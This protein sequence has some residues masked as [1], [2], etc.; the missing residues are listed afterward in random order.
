MHNGTA[1]NETVTSRTLVILLASMLLG[2]A[3][4]LPAVMMSYGM[5]TGTLPLDW[6]SY[7]SQLSA[8]RRWRGIPLEFFQLA[9]CLLAAAG[10]AAALRA[11]RADVRRQTVSVIFVIGVPMAA[12]ALWLAMARPMAYTAAAGTALGLL[13]M[14]IAG[15]ELSSLRDV[16]GNL[17]TVLGSPVPRTALLAAVAVTILGGEVIGVRTRMNPTEASDL[18]YRRGF[19]ASRP[20]TGAEY[21]PTGDAI[22]V[23]AFTDYECPVCSMAMPTLA[24]T[25]STFSKEAGRPTELV[26]HD[27]PLEQECNRG[28]S[29]TM[30]PMACE[31]AAA[32]RLVRRV[33]GDAEADQFVQT[34]YENNTE[35]KPIVDAQLARLGLAE[36]FAREYESLRGEVAADAAKGVAA[37]VHG[38]PS[39]F[40]NGK[41]VRNWQRLPQALRLEHALLSAPAGRTAGE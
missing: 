38:T 41:N 37:G 26:L 25:L 6:V 17:R 1:H 20:L 2:A 18:L 30:H 15:G 13:A 7:I 19:E 34:L 16:L 28:R 32:V 3:A 24:E 23:V 35:L 12:C 10:L 5:A 36:T 8:M 27:Y 11:A 4:W 40:V 9:W 22:K 21:Q 33:A 14:L 39:I 29:D 31:A